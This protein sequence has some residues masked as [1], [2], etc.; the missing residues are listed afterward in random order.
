[1]GLTDNLM[2]YLNHFHMAS[3]GMNSYCCLPIFYLKIYK[4]IMLYL[5]RS[6]AL[7]NNTSSLA[8][9]SNNFAAQVICES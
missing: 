6:S 8:I 1:M 3:K 2:Q 9:H 5:K 7:K 4:R